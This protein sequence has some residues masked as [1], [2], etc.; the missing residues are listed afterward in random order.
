MAALV[1]ESKTHSS[2]QTVPVA[3]VLVSE[4]WWE[5]LRRGRLGQES[6][7]GFGEN[8]QDAVACKRS[9]CSAFSRI[10]YRSAI[11]KWDCAWLLERSG[12]TYI[13]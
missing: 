2:V 12:R 11:A 5:D 3:L 10:R 4:W 7:I 13:G 8:S 9:P 1:A 6:G